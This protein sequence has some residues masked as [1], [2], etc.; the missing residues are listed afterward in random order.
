MQIL[1]GKA[2]AE[3]IRQEITAE[4][5]K[6]K[7]E[8]G[9]VPCLAALI[10]GD[11]PASHIYVNNKEKACLQVGIESR[12]LRLPDTTTTIELL[13]H[14]NQFNAD[15]SVH[16]IL[17]Q[18]PLPKSC[19]E[20]QILDAIDPKKDVDAFHPNNVGLLSQGRP[21]FLPCTPHGVQQLL[22][23]SGIQTA[24]QHVVVVGRSDIVGKPMALMM[25]QKN[26][27]ADSTVTIVHS[28]TK[29][30]ADLTRQADILIVAIGKA[31][32]V[33]GS[34]VKRGA[35]VVD[36]GINRLSDGKICG[37]VDFDEVK[38]IASAISPV[39]GGVGPLTITMLL[40]NTFNA[41]GLQTG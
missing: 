31:K 6:L 14:I 20:Q 40:Q 26:A 23:R 36:V 39:P 3:E 12:I 18:L 28:R 4:V 38:E 29:N 10:V 35:V 1:D 33:T 7:S 30:L 8:Q 11:D 13:R 2:I 17:I 16:G 37:D 21:R 19:D 22:I 27:D 15:P 32:F 34:M 24:G 5:A 9:I 41:C 25:V